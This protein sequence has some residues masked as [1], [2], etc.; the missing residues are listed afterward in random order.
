MNRRSAAG[1]G[2]AVVLAGLG[3]TGAISWANSAKSSA[4]AR[5]TQTAVVIVDT[6]VPKGADATT[7]EAAPHEGTVQQKAIAPGALTSEAQIGSQ[8]A[9][10]D[11]LPGDQLVKDRL[12]ANVD[13]RPTAAFRKPY[14]PH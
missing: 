8:V 2:V 7:I 4:E 10:A 11:L 1:I 3:A 9:L 12:G 5:E 14:R 13:E 6:R